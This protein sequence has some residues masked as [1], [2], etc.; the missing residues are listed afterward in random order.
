MALFKFQNLNKYGTLRTRIIYSPTSQLTINPR[1]LG[2]FI[3][4]QKF[5]YE[6]HH[7]YMNP[8]FQI[9]DGEKLIIPGDI[10]VHPET[11]FNDINW[12]KPKKKKRS[13]PI[14]EIN[15]S[16]SSDIE[17]TTKYYPDSGKYHC[18]CP[19]V[20]RSKD[21]RCKHIKAMELKK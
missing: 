18:T 10:K 6:Y 19:G 16:S 15:T 3:N 7:A 1:G 11:T 9:K 12:I 5:R 21:R 14:I 2:N 17:Y 8:Q 13:D 20:W 4:V